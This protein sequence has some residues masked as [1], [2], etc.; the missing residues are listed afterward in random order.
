MKILLFLLPEVLE[1][2]KNKRLKWIAGKRK[3]KIPKP[4]AP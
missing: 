1:G 2:N 4:F 3:P